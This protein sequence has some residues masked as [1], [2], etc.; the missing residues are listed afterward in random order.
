[1]RSLLPRTIQA[2]LILSHLL[3]SLVSIVIISIYAAG[4]LNNALYSQVRYQYQ[5]VGLVALDAL[6]EPFQAF[7][8]AAN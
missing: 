6:K 4:A 2:R 5:D 3:V 7:R 1:M 8:S